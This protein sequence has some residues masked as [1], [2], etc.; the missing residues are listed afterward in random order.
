M[1]FVPNRKISVHH[2]SFWKFIFLSCTHS[3]TRKYRSEEEAE[4]ARGAIAYV[5]LFAEY[6]KSISNVSIWNQ[7]CK[8]GWATVGFLWN[9]CCLMCPKIESR[10]DILI[11]F[12]FAFVWKSS[13]KLRSNNDKHTSTDTHTQNV[14]WIEIQLDCVKRTYDGEYKIN[15]TA[16]AAASPASGSAK[17]N[18]LLQSEWYECTKRSEHQTS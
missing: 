9:R 13:S 2:F 15:T 1:S 10:N 4:R 11:T 6:R 14:K 18:M 3:R 16:A 17:T 7:S 5:V 8:S 12:S